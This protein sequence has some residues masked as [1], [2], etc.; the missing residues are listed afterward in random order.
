MP[1]GNP[2]F[3]I[4]DPATGKVS[5]QFR[6]RIFATGI[7][8]NAGNDSTGGAPQEEVITFKKPNFAFI[9]AF[10]AGNYDTLAG[11]DAGI[12]RAMA[13][14]GDGPS[15][16]E[17]GIVAESGE[18]SA[19]A[20][21]TKI[22]ARAFHKA[23]SKLWQPTIINGAGASNFWEKQTNGGLPDTIQMKMGQTTM[24]ALPVGAG[25]QFPI[26][27]GLP[28]AN[29]NLFLGFAQPTAS[30]NGVFYGGSGVQSTTQGFVAVY[31]QTTVQAFLINWVSFGSI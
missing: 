28:W 17:A 31:N 6:G 4:L 8:L 25:P 24:G 5:F 3:F 19:G 26:V 16:S 15:P 30:W 29:H 14:A 10:I 27:S 1:K 9:P 18:D 13:Q 21:F 20:S 22:T 7:Q 12:L 11:G 23:T 2:T